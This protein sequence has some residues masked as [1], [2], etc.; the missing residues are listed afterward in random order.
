MDHIGVYLVALLVSIAE[1]VA[2]AVHEII[3]PVIPGL[4]MVVGV[5]TI[6]IIVFS[7]LWI[8]SRYSHYINIKWWR[9]PFKS[10]KM[11][12]STPR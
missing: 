8:Y 6:I 3:K 2:E 9:S 12:G 11:A 7:F 1:F 4:K 10:F 5:S